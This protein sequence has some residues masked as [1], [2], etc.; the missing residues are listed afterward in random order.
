MY[1]KNLTYS[2]VWCGHM[3]S[4]CPD[5]GSQVIQA[6]GCWYCVTCGL[7]GCGNGVR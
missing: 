5:C 2:I 1:K 7:E 6:G 3:L 4:H